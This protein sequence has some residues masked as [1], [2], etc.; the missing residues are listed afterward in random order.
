[1]GLAWTAVGGELLYIEVM[2]VIRMGGGSTE[3]PLRLVT[4]HL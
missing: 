1:M 2:R 3:Q 4:V